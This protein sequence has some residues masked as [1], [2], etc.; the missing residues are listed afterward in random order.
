MTDVTP[1]AAAPSLLH[2]DSSA[3]GPVEAVT[4]QLT[5]LFAR[6]WRERHEAAGVRPAYRYRYR[7]LAAEPVPPLTAAYA[8]LGRRAER[9]G[10]R[11]PGEVAALAATADE[12]R[13]WARTRP[14]I[15]E[16]REAGILLIGVPMYNFAVPAALKAWIDRVCFPG[17]F[18]D[19]DTGDSL[20]RGTRVVLAL[21]R[22]GGYGPGSPR[23]DCDFQ[24]PY[25]RALFGALGVDGKDLH[26]VTAEFTRAGDVP[27]LAAFRDQAAR[28]A[29]RARARA[30]AL[31]R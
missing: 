8:A 17:A 4:R 18:T 6:T 1:K 23:E 27:A 19:P 21:A 14:L 12:E 13:E 10:A 11:S 30:V 24:L 7:D 28:S 22:G 29:E 9:N 31:A 25:L 3:D 20:L 2:L 26:A 16:V 5:A 15:E